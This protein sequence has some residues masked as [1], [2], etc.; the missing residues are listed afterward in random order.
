MSFSAGKR[1]SIAVVVAAVVAVIVV[2]VAA[3]AAAAIWLLLVVA[4]AVTAET[5]TWLSLLVLCKLCILYTA[6][7]AVD[8]RL[9][10]YVTAVAAMLSLL[11]FILRAAIEAAVV[12]LQLTTAELRRLLRQQ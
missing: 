2:V 10:I 4:A 11:W 8:L 3:A 5:A 1:N 12:V 6:C 7:C 9:I